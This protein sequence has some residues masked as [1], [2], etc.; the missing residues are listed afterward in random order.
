MK[1]IALL[2]A[3]VCQPWYAM[4]T[5]DEQI[6]H[7]PDLPL[8]NIVTKD[9]VEMQNNIISAPEGCIGTTTDNEYVG[10]SMIMTFKGDT[11][12]NTGNYVP[13]ESGMRI[14]I[15][16]N[17]TGANNV[18]HPYKLKLTKKADLIS[19]QN[20]IAPDKE[21]VLLN[22]IAW[23]PSFSTNCSSILTWVG[24]SIGRILQMDF[25]PRTNFVNVVINGKYEGLYTLI[26]NVK[27][28][29]NRI[30]IHKSGFILEN[31]IFWWNSELTFQTKYLPSFMGYTFKYPDDD[32]ITDEQFHAIEQY[33]NDFEKALYE[34]G[35]I[36]R[37]I[38]L[39]SFARW[40]LSHDILG[41]FDAG[42]TN[43]FIS[44]DRFSAE[45]PFEGG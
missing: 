45:N 8:L 5:N 6:K 15:R 16:G 11:L 19:P 31:D 33:I 30:D 37:F 13:D 18:Q 20:P 32:E 10:A 44:K 3:I 24:G 12:L 42:G 39:T 43:M 7:W 35:D 23:N 26:E 4:A 36:N 40:I 14:R 27:R 38:D 21:W 22:A 28:S 2:I 1:R 17:S 25:V 9:S 34:N 41:S 29:S